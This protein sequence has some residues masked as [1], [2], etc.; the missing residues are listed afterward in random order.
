[1]W[2][3]RAT[4]LTEIMI[5]KPRP[6]IGGHSK[7][8]KVVC[9]ANL[10]P[11]RTWWLLTRQSSFILKSSCINIRF[12][13]YGT[14]TVTYMSVD[15]SNSLPGDF[16]KYIMTENQDP[17]ILAVEDLLMGRWRSFFL[18]D[19]SLCSSYFLLRRKSTSAAAK[20]DATRSRSSK[21]EAKTSVGEKI[22]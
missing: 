15:M 3:D 16:T 7:L 11:L 5:H 2:L 22:K 12:P 8:H 4:P 19:S 13:R 21:R 1:M 20:S 9:T 18:K 17:P 14:T 6:A 10:H